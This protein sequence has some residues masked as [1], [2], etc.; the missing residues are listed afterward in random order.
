MFHRPFT[1]ACLAYSPRLP[2]LILECGTS[3]RGTGDAAIPC[4]VQVLE[5]VSGVEDPTFG[6]P[7]SFF[8]PLPTVCLCSVFQ[9][10]T[11]VLTPGFCPFFLAF[12]SSYICTILGRQRCWSIPALNACFCCCLCLIVLYASF[13]V[14]FSRSDSRLP[15]IRFCLICFLYRSKVVLAVS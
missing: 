4:K 6:E 14:L 3:K 8:P 12:P 11:C 10:L 15:R 2:C 5:R 9:G 1:A 7:V 13:S